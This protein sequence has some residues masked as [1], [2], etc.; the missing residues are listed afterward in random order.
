MSSL[1]D[2]NASSRTNKRERPND[3]DL[4]ASTDTS[5]REEQATELQG[6]PADGQTNGLF[7]DAESFDVSFT[8]TLVSTYRPTTFGIQ[9]ATS[10]SHLEHGELK[11]LRGTKLDPL[12]ALLATQPA[13]VLHALIDLSR[14]ML[15]LG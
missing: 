2:E 11:A 5:T 8:N 15:A 14:S 3:D 1:Q 13:K 4:K 6:R 10:T 9:P 7:D 12:R